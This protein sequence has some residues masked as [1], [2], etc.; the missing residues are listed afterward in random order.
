MTDSVC[1]VSVVVVGEVSAGRVD[2]RGLPQLP[3]VPHAGCEREDALADARP[4]AVGD[5]GAVVF[6]TELALEGVVDRFDPLTDRAELAEPGP[7][8]V[9]VGTDERGVQRVDDLFEL[10]A[11][12]AFVGDDDLAAGQ[13]AVATSAVEQR[14][15]DLAL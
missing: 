9:A 11:G 10:V 7:L 3:A 1:T 15:G 2:E 12:E 14:C 4:D 13:Q 5:V 6:E 8:V